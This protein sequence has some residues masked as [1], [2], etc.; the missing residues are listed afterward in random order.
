MKAVRLISPG[1]V[2]L[3][4]IPT[5]VPRKDQMLIRTGASTL[6]TSDLNDIKT[7]PF[8]ISLPVTL[9][10]EG[11]GTVVQ[12]GDD[13]KG[14]QIGDRVT[15]HPVHSCGNCSSCRDGN[16]HLCLNMEHF[17][18]NLPGTMAE[19]YLVRHDRARRIPDSVDF[20]LA[21]LA[22]PVSVCLEALSQAR[23]SPGDRLLIIGDGPFGVMMTRLASQM[24]LDRL[25]TAGYSDFRLSF[26]KNSTIVN[27]RYA[28]DPVASMSFV[29]ERQAYD[30]VII[31]AGFS[32]AF[33]DGIKCLKPKGRLV[34]FAS[35][36]EYTPVDLFEVQFKELEIIGACNDQDRFDDAV[37]FLADQS[38]GL[39]ELITHRLPLHEY[40]TALDLAEN[41][42]DETLKVTLI[43]GS[44]I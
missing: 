33:Q 5:P 8:H 17:G 36:H 26:I 1:Q 41:H 10:H 21:T 31:A 7:N 27:T 29:N 12:L 6:C 15:T 24:R 32:Q 13:V 34:V 11:A 14:F 35:I 23:L 40:Q 42:P 19:Y 30:A 37:S 4:D 22:E 18:I 9:G 20:A 2:I 28:T 38:L 16:H 39:H 44:T 25:V 43:P 3:A